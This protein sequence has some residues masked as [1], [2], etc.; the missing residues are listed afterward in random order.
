MIRV[1][2]VVKENWVNERLTRCLRNRKFS[3]AC[4][5]RSPNCPLGESV[6]DFSAEHPL[7]S[8]ALGRIASII[9]HAAE[10]MECQKFG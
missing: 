4:F 10:T 3:I 1:G 2:E 5:R 9:G 7:L 6:H 8:P